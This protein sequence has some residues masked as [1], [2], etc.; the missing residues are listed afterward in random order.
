[1]TAKIV[2]L[3]GRRRLIG[4]G[5]GRM[6]A[7][8]L[9]L[10]AVTS[11]AGLALVASGVAQEG[12]SAITPGIIAA[13]GGLVLIGLAVLV[14]EL[15]RIER[16]LAVRP[17]PRAS[18]PGEVPAGVAASEQANAPRIPFPPKPKVAPPQ[19]G[20]ISVPA[21]GEETAAAERLRERFPS[22]VRLET[23]PVVEG[24]DV[25]LL[26]GHPTRAE[27][28]VGEGENRVAVGRASGVASV[29]IAP[30]RDVAARPLVSRERQ[31]ATVFESFWPKGQRPK[32]DAQTATAHAAAEQAAPEAEPTLGSGAEPDTRPAIAES[33]ASVTVLKS[34]VVEGMAYTLYSD[35]SIEAQLP[36]GTLR[37]GSITELRDHIQADS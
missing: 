28:V 4:A 17:M 36:Q 23:A 8:L 18:R 24:A 3:C 11:A 1:M 9:I 26:P 32:Q 6:Y 5:D 33:A 15:Q 30:R 12:V 14:R 16:A 34:G 19:V 37:F 2:I 22:L 13:T 7:F 21:S 35:G 25:S 29:R 20:A 31:K 27:E 10:G